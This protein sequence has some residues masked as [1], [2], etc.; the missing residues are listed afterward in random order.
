MVGDKQVKLKLH[1]EKNVGYASEIYIGSG[2]PQRIRVLFDT[3]SANSWV[4]ST[5]AAEKSTPD[6]RSLHNFFDQELSTTFVD[7][8]DK[9]KKVKI[10][11]SKYKMKVRI[12][13]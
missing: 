3:G 7:N 2:Q 12:L 1:N 6:F 5:Y 8:E 11:L 4:L 10:R 13:K 9:S